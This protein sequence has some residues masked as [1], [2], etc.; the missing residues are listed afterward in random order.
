MFSLRWVRLVFQPPYRAKWR[1]L[2]DTT[3]GQ[4][5]AGRLSRA[6]AGRQRHVLALEWPL[7]CG[8]W[9]CGGKITEPHPKVG[10]VEAA[11]LCGLDKGGMEGCRAGH[12]GGSCTPDFE[13]GCGGDA[14]P[15]SAGPARAPGQPS[16]PWE[17]AV[18]RKPA[19]I[20]NPGC[21]SAI[22][23]QKSFVFEPSPLRLLQD[24]FSIWAV[25]DLQT[26]KL[27]MKNSVKMLEIGA[28]LSLL[29]SAVLLSSSLAGLHPEPGRASPQR[30][31]QA[32]IGA[33]SYDCD[34]QVAWLAAVLKEPRTTQLRLRGG[35]EQRGSELRGPAVL[36]PPG[37]P[38]PGGEMRACAH[39]SA[40]ETASTLALC[41][42]CSKPSG[43]RGR[44]CRSVLAEVL[45]GCTA[46]VG[47]PPVSG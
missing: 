25:S 18:G 47:F 32:S 29:L 2:Q 5:L 17:S 9:G 16:W 24:T 34:A 31:G 40:L 43:D 3:S 33:V 4:A 30:R 6:E 36:P 45:Q 1:F 41:M 37:P 44:G 15:E 13:G 21:G 8:V 42:V 27:E 19:K 7:G 28:R 35:S 11:R 20:S 39:C 12:R 14:P 23:R 38:L 10:G 46:W 26:K 22:F